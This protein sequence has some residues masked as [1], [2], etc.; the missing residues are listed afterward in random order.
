MSRLHRRGLESL[1]KDF[2]YLKNKLQL[3]V[4]KIHIDFSMICFDIISTCTVNIL[5]Y[6]MKNV[7]YIVCTAFIYVHCSI[8]NIN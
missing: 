7:F 3:T 4:S 1:K 2:G 6:S 5:V 8:Q